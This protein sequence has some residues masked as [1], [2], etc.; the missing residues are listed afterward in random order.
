MN[1]RPEYEY[2]RSVLESNVEDKEAK[3]QMEFLLKQLR[4]DAPE[5]EEDSDDED[6]AVEEEEE[7]DDPEELEEDIERG[8][9]LR[10][11]SGELEGERLLT[12]RYS[13]V[14]D[15]EDDD[16][17]A[18]VGGQDSNTSVGLWLNEDVAASRELKAS[19]TIIMRPT[20]PSRL[21]DDV[22]TSAELAALASPRH[23]RTSSQGSRRPL[24]T[25]LLASSVASTSASPAPFD[26]VQSGS[27][28]SF[29]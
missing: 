22:M 29:A 2:Y 1:C 6:V 13:I 17:G 18:T 8:D 26:V 25:S 12:E 20:T 21:K 28:W 24:R 4:S 10:A 11:I 3:S 7:E 15:S 5:P 27:V 19:T 16:D 23:L 14:V 9:P